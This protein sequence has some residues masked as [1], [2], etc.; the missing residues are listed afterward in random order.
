[1]K[2]RVGILPVLALILC[3]A[4]AFLWSSSRIG[5]QIKDVETQLDQSRVQLTQA[6]NEQAQLKAMLDMVDTEAFIENQARSLYGYMRPDE[7]RFVI[8]NPEALYADDEQPTV[9]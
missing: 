9:P 3:L 7:I 1:M 8:N 6:Q 4:G 5:N 2:R